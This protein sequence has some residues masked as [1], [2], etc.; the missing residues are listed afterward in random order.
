MW[1]HVS[2]R[3]HK[4]APAAPPAAWGMYATKSEEDTGVIAMIDLL[5][6]DLTKE[7]TEAADEKDS[8]AGY[9]Q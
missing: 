1:A 6:K 9:Q 4:A 3:Q 8:H 2:N 5:V 7:T